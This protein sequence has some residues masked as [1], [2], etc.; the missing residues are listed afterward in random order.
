MALRSGQRVLVVLPL[1][2]SAEGGLR[3]PLPSGTPSLIFEFCDQNGLA[4]FGARIWTAQ[5]E[6]LRR[7]K[8]SL[9]REPTSGQKKHVSTPLRANSFSYGTEGALCKA[10]S[11]WSCE[12]QP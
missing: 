3:G 9:E 1:E 6:F 5:G 4:Q 2:P 11:D 12:F 8:K 7:E 10:S